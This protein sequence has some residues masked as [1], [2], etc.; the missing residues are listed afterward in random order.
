VDEK[1]GRLPDA[2]EEISELLEEQVSA[3]S[4]TLFSF[5]FPC[6]LAATG[7]LMG[8]VFLGLVYPYGYLMNQLSG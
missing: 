1:G 5:L 8:M 6:A 4:D 2:V 3:L 7:V